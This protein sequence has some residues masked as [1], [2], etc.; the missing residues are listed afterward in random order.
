MFLYDPPP[1]DFDELFNRVGGDLRESL[2]KLETMPKDLA[3]AISEKF[4]FDPSTQAAQDPHNPE[5]SK[6]EPYETWDHSKWLTMERFNND[7]RSVL[8]DTNLSQL[9]DSPDA[10]ADE[11][12]GALLRRPVPFVAMVNRHGEF[13]RLIDWQ[14]LIEQVA[15]KLGEPAAQP[16]VAVAAK[17]E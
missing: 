8:F 7:V 15:A 9:E 6:L 14:V 5:W 3:K 12:T 17:R 10:L 16:R 11:R 13:Q 2:A 1:K 4:I